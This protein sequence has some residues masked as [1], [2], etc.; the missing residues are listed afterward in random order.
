MSLTSLWPS[1]IDLQGHVAHA[2]HF[3]LLH[4]HSGALSETLFCCVSVSCA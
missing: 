3:A 2:Y 1:K 4:T